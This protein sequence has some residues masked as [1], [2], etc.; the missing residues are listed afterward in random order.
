MAGGFEML[1][2]GDGEGEDSGDYGGA[3]MV[4]MFMVI[5]IMVLW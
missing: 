1:V 4:A 3:V 2:I 5:T